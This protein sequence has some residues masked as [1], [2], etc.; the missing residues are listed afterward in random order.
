MKPPAHLHPLTRTL[1]IIAACALAMLTAAHA[2]PAVPLVSEAAPAPAPA[3]D[4]PELSLMKQ[5]EAHMAEQRHEQAA[6]AFMQAAAALD[7]SAE[8]ALVQKKEALRLAG[9]T[10]MRVG[11]FRKSLE[12]HQ[13]WLALEDKTTDPL[14]W[15]KVADAVMNLRLHFANFDEAE[16]LAREALRIREQELG[17]KH[18]EVAIGL[19]NLAQILPA[20]NEWEEAESLYTRALAI[21]EAHYGPEHRNVAIRLSKLAGILFYTNHL[22]EAESLMRRALA[23]NEATYGPE[24]FA[25]A[26]LLNNLA[27][28][29]QTANRMEEAEALRRRALPI[30]EENLGPEHGVV[31]QQHIDLAQLLMEM[32]QKAEAE[33]LMQRAIA[34]YENNYGSW[35]IMLAVELQKCAQLLQKKKRFAGAEALYRRALSIFL[36]LQ[37]DAGIRPPYMQQTM[38]NYTALLEAM[39][40]TPEQAQANIEALQRE[41]RENWQREQ[42]KG[43]EKQPEEPIKQGEGG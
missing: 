43:V 38:E 25:V 32:N 1:L 41:V 11:E 27:D 20:T 30:Y 23:I 9:E 16:S 21:D 42:G 37:L 31:A 17:P 2:D 18:P 10:Y 22:D 40:Q 5:A 29:L 35:E 15:V 4:Q 26:P 28:V 19:N 34:I 36:R 13:Q 39:G 8:D 14:C 24:N 33:S 3:N 6:D 7:E 12:A